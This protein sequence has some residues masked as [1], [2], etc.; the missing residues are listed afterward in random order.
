MKKNYSYLELTDDQTECTKTSDEK[1]ILRM[2]LELFFLD[3]FECNG[4]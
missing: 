1:S 3:E 4:Q 2:N